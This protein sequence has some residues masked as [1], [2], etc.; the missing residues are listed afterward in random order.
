MQKE[1]NKL[2][3]GKYEKK[4]QK[5]SRVGRFSGFGGSGLA[6]LARRQRLGII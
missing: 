5:Q 3:R 1:N 6:V 2:S 4:N